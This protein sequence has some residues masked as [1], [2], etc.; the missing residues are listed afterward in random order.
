MKLLGFSSP[1]S[2]TVCSSCKIIK[3]STLLML[4]LS[5]SN[6]CFIRNKPWF[7]KDIVEV[8]TLDLLWFLLCKILLAALFFLSAGGR[9]FIFF[10]T[11]MFCSQSPFPL[12]VFFLLLFNLIF[13]NIN[14][15]MD[16]SSRLFQLLLQKI[17]P[18]L[19]LS[20]LECSLIPLL[21]QTTLWFKL[22]ECCVFSLCKLLTIISFT[23][24]IIILL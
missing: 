5:I 15:Y 22:V 6:I 3:I 13:I 10:Y 17:L 21:W 19:L 1:R 2:V 8:L 11:S 4:M 16:T 20:I 24:T 23:F 12:F 7:N 18:K 9:I 14:P